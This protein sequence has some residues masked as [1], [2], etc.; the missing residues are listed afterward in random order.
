MRRQKKRVGFEALKTNPFSNLEETLGNRFLT[1]VDQLDCSV[2]DSC[3]FEVYDPT[4]IA[5]FEVKLAD[6]ANFVVASAKIIADGL[7]FQ[8][9]ET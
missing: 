8:S 2:K 6:I 4:T 5:R 7:Q 9:T 1:C 3:I